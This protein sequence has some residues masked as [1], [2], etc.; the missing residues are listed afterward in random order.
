MLSAPAAAQAPAGFW[1]G[2]Y[3]TSATERVTVYASNSYPVDEA[4]T[5]RWANFVGSLVHG[6]ELSSVSV[7]LAPPAEVAR[8]CGGREAYGCYANNRIVARGED[9]RAATTASVLAHEYGHHIATHRSNAPWR[10][11]AWGTKRWASYDQVCAKTEAKQM[12]PGSQS[13][14]LYM[15]NPGEGFAEAYRVLNENRAGLPHGDWLVDEI[16]LP[17]ERALA[18][19][20]QDVVDPWSANTVVR[21]NGRF[22]AR[23]KVV[24]TFRVATPLDGELSVSVQGRP[25]VRIDVLAG[26][27]RLE[28]GNTSATSWL[29]CGSR[30]VTVRA[31]R[32]AGGG[33]FTLSVSRP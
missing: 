33:P 7:L 18:L 6:A 17:N 29:V 30:T 11:A 14:L 2:T 25:R 8:M 20:E 24:R 22:P 27:K 13:A 5:Q 4:V 10:A 9:T 15:F 28:R 3:S 16:F 26:K 32:L 23:G 12:F 31:T 21:L 1:G 19:I